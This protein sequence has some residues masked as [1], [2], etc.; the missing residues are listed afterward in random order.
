[1]LIIFLIYTALYLYNFGYLPQPFFYDTFDTYM[2]WFNTAYWAHSDGMYRDWGSIYPPLSFVFFKIIS[3]PRCYHNKNTFIGPG[4]YYDSRECDWIAM[5]AL[6]LFFFINI[7]LCYRMLNKIN[8]KTAIPRTILLSLGL[9]MVSALERGSLSIPTFTC[10]LLA[11]TPLLK[12]TR[13]KWLAL[14]LAINFKVYLIMSALPLLIKRKWLWVE[15]ALLSTLLVY[16]ITYIILGH[17]SPLEV[18]KNISS[19]SGGQVESSNILD[20]WYTVTYTVLG[21]LLVN[22]GFPIYALI[23][24]DTV[25]MALSAIVVSQRLVQSLL[26]FSLIMSWIRPE[27]VSTSRIAALGLSFAL[28]T[29][30]VGGYGQAFLYVFLLMEPWKG[31][32]LKFALTLCYIVSFPFDLKIS[33]LGPQIVSDSYLS[34]VNTLIQFKVMIGPYL[35]PGLILLIETSLACVTIADVWA[36]IRKQGWKSRWRY[37][38]D[39]PIMLGAGEIRPPTANSQL[40]DQRGSA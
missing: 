40:P 18:Y 20:A 8:P 3:T 6:F 19:Y 16:I 4:A 9:P 39:F 29:S 34:G 31:F 15:G 36:D 24:S 2:D 25:N 26:I 10:F 5:T 22:T 13:L 12:S 14:G 28:A 11:Y 17:G 32:G 23:G 35:R 30:E 38:R 37:R 21:A 1:M 27:A 33:D 7:Y